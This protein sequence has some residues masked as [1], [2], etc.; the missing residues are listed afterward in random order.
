MAEE[1]VDISK[2]GLQLSYLRFL[3]DCV[4][5][6]AF[7]ILVA[8]LGFTPLLGKPLY[9]IVP[10]EIPYHIQIFLLALTLPL[11]APLGLAMNAISYFAFGACSELLHK[12]LFNVNPYISSSK[13]SL[14][15]NK[16]KEKFCF[17]SNNWFYAVN[18]M[19]EILKLK[20][21]DIVGSLDYMRGMHRL[22]RIIAFIFWMLFSI[23][24]FFILANSYNKYFDV[25]PDLKIFV[26]SKIAVLS[27]FAVILCIL[28]SSIV[29]FHYSLEIASKCRLLCYDEENGEKIKNLIFTFTPES[30][31]NRT[32]LLTI[33]S[34]II[35][36]F[37]LMM[38]FGMI[39]FGKSAGV[40]VVGAFFFIASFFPFF[41]R[42][43]AKR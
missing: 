19:S 38:S 16:C 29:D 17:T 10:V 21:A 4:S 37:V 41:H 30:S 3:S 24:V 25:F 2:F 26:V 35:S 18:L 11:S 28:L 22:F 32:N 1:K 6:Y 39:I 27:L 8:V 43:T 7:I 23:L 36:S 13:S 42:N 9:N 20:H 15:F 12:F 5:G 14:L 34:I 33:A 31:N 40:M